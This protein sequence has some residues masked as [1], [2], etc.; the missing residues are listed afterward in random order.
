MTMGE[1]YEDMKEALKFF[2]LSFHQKDLVTVTIKDG[3]ITFT[4]GSRHISIGE[5]TGR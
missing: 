2:G 3:Q 5:A 4:Y 1:L